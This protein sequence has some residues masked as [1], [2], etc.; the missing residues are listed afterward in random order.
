MLSVIFLIYHQDLVPPNFC[1]L[2]CSIT[3]V[4]SDLYG[5]YVATYNN[6][7]PMYV[8]ATVVY[9]SFIYVV[10]CQSDRV[11]CVTEVRNKK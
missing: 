3:I 11:T 6:V 4:Y 2:R 7:L 8:H 10:T 9:I 5:K 1:H